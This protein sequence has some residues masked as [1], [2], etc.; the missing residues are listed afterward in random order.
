MSTEGHQWSGEAGRTI[1]QTADR[2]DPK[3]T[4]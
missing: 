1:L 4:P 2:I 3:E